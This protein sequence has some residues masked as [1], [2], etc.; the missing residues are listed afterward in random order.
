MAVVVEVPNGEALARAVI[1]GPTRSGVTQLLLS[2]NERYLAMYRYSGLSEEGSAPSDTCLERGIDGRPTQD[3][4][5]WTRQESNYPMAKCLVDWA[6]LRI[7]ELPPGCAT[8]ANSGS[9]LVPSFRL[10]VRKPSIQRA[11]RCRGGTSLSA[12][13]R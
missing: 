7:E 1:P 4:A 12:R 5:S 6:T 9:A 13:A 11:W 3:S 10:R 2:A 8:S